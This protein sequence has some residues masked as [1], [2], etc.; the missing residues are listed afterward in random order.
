[1]SS[2][3]PEPAAGWW[4]C[5][6][7]TPAYPVLLGALAGPPVLAVRGALDPTA[8]M[9]A[10][11]GARRLTAYGEELAYEIAR[12]VAAAGVVVVSGMARGVDAAAHRGALDAGGRTIAVMGTGPDSIYPPEHRGLAEQIA[13]SGALVTQFPAGARPL[14]GNFPTRNETISG[15][16]LGVV[17]VEA[18]R[19]SGAMLTA[20]AAGN[21][22]RI[23]MAVPGS[24]HNP[25][26][27]GC[28]D[29]IRDG[30]ILV[31]SAHEVLEAVVPDSLTD[32]LLP[33][34]EGAGGREHFGDARDGVIDALERG[35]LTLDELVDAVGDEASEV[36]S[37]AARL[38]LDG[39]IRLRD[40]AYGL[41]S[42]RHGRNRTPRNRVV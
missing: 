4:S 18:R 34:F 6:P 19:Q 22:N 14:R 39:L 30:A 21:Q 5:R 20:G 35:N 15:L 11:V 10:I 40:G 17:V 38:R 16:C 42:E 9:V 32:L 26:S 37:A 8:M 27:R 13:G 36:V 12:G 25:A 28:H 1:V 33:G 31:T 41:A 23:V 2:A 7:G 29:L 3:A 24:V